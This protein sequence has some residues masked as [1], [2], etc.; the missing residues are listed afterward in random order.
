[1][2]AR[3]LQIPGFSFAFR[4]TGNV[5]VFPLME[6]GVANDV[7]NNSNVRTTGIRKYKASRVGIASR[8]AYRDRDCRF[9]HHR[10]RSRGMLLKHRYLD[11]IRRVTGCRFLR[12]K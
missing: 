12:I 10:W 6:I 7:T 4:A 5:A 11:V 1:M 8:S 9:C 3:S 2:I